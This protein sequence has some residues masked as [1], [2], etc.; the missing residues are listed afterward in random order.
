MS[1]EAELEPAQAHL[2]ALIAK[3]GGNLRAVL[4]MLIEANAQLQEELDLTRA[5]VSSGYWRQW[6]R[7]RMQGD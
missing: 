5:A 3:H 2:D 7:R 1:T 6:H 4:E